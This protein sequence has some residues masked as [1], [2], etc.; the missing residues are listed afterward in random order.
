MQM[1]VQSVKK[2]VFDRLAEV[3]GA[4]E[5]NK[6]NLS[7]YTGTVRFDLCSK[8]KYLALQ[9]FFC[10]ENGLPQPLRGFAMTNLFRVFSY[11]TLCFD[12][13]LLL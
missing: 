13:R 10:K 12:D 11:I 9:A 3:K 2:T 1:A 8:S 7:A 6:S 4:S 5:T